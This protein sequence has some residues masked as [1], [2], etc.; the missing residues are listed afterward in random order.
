MKKFLIAAVALSVL[1]S[2]GAAAAQP[3]SGAGGYDRRDERRDDRYDR[4][5]DRR[6]DRSDRR[7]DRRDDRAD[8]RGDRAD[9]RYERRADR[10][11]NAGRYHAPRGYQQD[12]RWSRGQYLPPAYR[13]RGYYV[14]YRAYHLAP[15][16]RGYG[17]YRHGDDVILTAIA[18]GLIASVVFNLFD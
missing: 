13:D 12:R 17:Y 18:T 3:Y 9:S 2:A 6:D 14:D 7:D 5:D 11:Y 4:R 10:R 16:P 15:P 8:R 1:G